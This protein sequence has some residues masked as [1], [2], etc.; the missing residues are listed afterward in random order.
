VSDWTWEY[1]PDS[2]HV[3]GGLTPG[4]RAE[5]EA[6]A[7]RIADAVTVRMIGRPFNPEEAVSGLKSYGEGLV[8]LWYQEDY[9]DDTVVICR[10]QQV[11]VLA[12]HGHQVALVPYQGPV[13]QL[14]PAGA[15][16]AF[17][18]RVHS[19]RLNSGADHPGASGLEDGAGRGGEA[20]VPVMQDELHAHPAS[21]KSIS[22][23][24]AC[25]TTQDWTGFSVAPRIR[26]RR[27]PCPV[28]AK[29]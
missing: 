3:V 6:L 16:P 9:R 8:T 10:V 28:T 19:R 5:V 2:A 7:Q 26:I 1:V 15:D 25:C 13:R 21:S 29:T 18:D 12:Q 23:F 24:L 20:G 22:R 27:V 14:T 4:Q 11:L 17:H